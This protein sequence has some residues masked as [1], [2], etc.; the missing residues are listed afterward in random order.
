MD[1]LTDQD[2]YDKAAL[3]I[4][5]DWGID[6]DGPVE[7]DCIN[8]IYRFPPNSPPNS[9]PQFTLFKAPQWWGAVC[10]RP[11]SCKRCH[12]AQQ[13][14]L[15]T[16]KINL[17]P[18]L[19]IRGVVNCAPNLPNHH[20]PTISY[21]RFP[22]GKWKKYSGEDDALLEDFVTTFLQVNNIITHSARMRAGFCPT[23]LSKF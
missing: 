6:P 16:T 10:W 13:V 23:V 4:F 8:P 12:T 20:E 14:F 1:Q 11:E 18:R 7:D 2:F 19:G 5:K 22:I 3:S 15:E 9:F 21:L 17:L